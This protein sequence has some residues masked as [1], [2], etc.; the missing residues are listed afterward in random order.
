M[1]LR[2]MTLMLYRVKNHLLRAARKKTL[3]QI[4]LDDINLPAFTLRA[5]PKIIF[6]DIN[7][8]TKILKTR[9][10]MK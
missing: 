9:R 8:Q 6:V 5:A 1:T 10:L 3:A 2:L 4:T 7:G